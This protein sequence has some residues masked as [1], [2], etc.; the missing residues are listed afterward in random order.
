MVYPELNR[1]NFA[2]A[3]IHGSNYQ[4]LRLPAIAPVLDPAQFEKRSKAYCEGYEKFLYQYIAQQHLSPFSPYRGLLLY[5]GLGFGKTCSAITFAEAWLDKRVGTSANH[6]VWVITSSALMDNFKS[7]LYRKEAGTKQCMGEAYR[8]LTP[9]AIDAR[10]TFFTYDKFGTAVKEKAAARKLNAW[11]RNRILIIDEAHN[12]RNPTIRGALGLETFLKAGVNNRLVLLSATPMFDQP[13]ELTQLLYYLV[14]NDH[15]TDLPM[16]P[17]EIQ[18]VSF[19]RSDGGL[20]QPWIEVFKQLCGNYLSYVKGRNPFTLATRLTPAHSGLPLLTPATVPKDPYFSKAAVAATSRSGRGQGQWIQYIEDGLY[21]T[22]LSPIHSDVLFHTKFIKETVRTK[23][24]QMGQTS[25]DTNAPIHTNILEGTNVLYP[26]SGKRGKKYLVGSD[27]FQAILKP[28]AIQN[29]SKVYYNYYSKP[30]LYPSNA[31]LKTYAGKLYAAAKCLQASTGIVLIYSHFIWSGVMP[32][33]VVLEHLGYNRF[34]DTNLLKPGAAAGVGAGAE[35][36][37]G[38][39]P[40]TPGRHYAILCS[41]PTISGVD[42]FQSLLDVINGDSNQ[43]GEQIKVILM[44]PVA[45]EGIS[46]KNVREVHILDPW[47]HLNR[48]EQVIGRSI[49]TCSHQLLPLN[50]RNVTVFLHVSQYTPTDVKSKNNTKN[51]ETY[52]LYTYRIASDKKQKMDDIEMLIRDNALDCALQEAVNYYPKRLF[53]FDLKLTTSQNVET[54]V[55]LG[56]MEARKPHCQA[57]GAKRVT[58]RGWR[59]ELYEPLKEVSKERLRKFVVANGGEDTHTHHWDIERLFQHLKLPPELGWLALED[60]KTTPFTVNDRPFV[61][62]YHRMKVWLKPL[63]IPRVPRRIPIR[64]LEPKPKTNAKSAE[65]EADAEADDCSSLVDNLLMYDFSS[66]TDN[67]SIVMV[68]F[69]TLLNV[70]CWESMAQRIV[71]ENIESPLTNV[72]WKQGWL[73][74]PQELPGI[75]AGSSTRWV[76]YTLMDVWKK[77]TDLFVR[78]YTRDKASPWRDATTEETRR[79]KAGRQTAPEMEPLYGFYSKFQKAGQATVFK[80]KVMLDTTAKREKTGIVGT[81]LTSI[82]LRDLIVR[83][84]SQLPV[85]GTPRP[86]FEGKTGKENYSNRT[87]LSSWVAYYLGMLGRLRIPPYYKPL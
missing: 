84:Q 56:D 63:D 28:I 51:K 16:T 82:V 85:S 30:Y 67:D 23:L 49:R 46:F 61:L 9:K 36:G 38:E 48:L 52:D 79:L 74:A 72:L 50:E 24:M 75:A 80:F 19:Y 59:P 64:A 58:R 62:T 37:G 18:K 41:D 87:Y 83:L 53:P 10:Y 44:S 77:D 70:D 11:A 22:E 3:L 47:Y 21:A 39:L 60:L 76:G 43:H 31:Y 69:L 29:S 25:E 57:N 86:N 78:V 35:G 54:F 5:H 32:M 8:Y 2:D 27:G 26:G 66:T 15:R 12:L 71:I 33:A 40:K 34:Q 45:S 73:V 6:E 81:S 7:Q 68:T 17:A 13:D 65:A 42:N 14:L 4:A 20:N 1:P 55:S